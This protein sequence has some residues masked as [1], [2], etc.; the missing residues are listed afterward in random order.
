MANIA[1]KAYFENHYAADFALF[2]GDTMCGITMSEN[3]LPEK[4]SKFVGIAEFIVSQFELNLLNQ[5]IY[6]HFKSNHLARQNF[7]SPFANT[8]LCFAGHGMASHA[9]HSILRFVQDPSVRREAVPVLIAWDLLT[10][11]TRFF[12]NDYFGQFLSTSSD[13]MLSREKFVEVL[14]QD[15]DCVACVQNSNGWETRHVTKLLGE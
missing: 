8:L 9:P 4:R 11:Y 7:S 1:P 15:F 3:L 2:G 5:V 14:E 13:K 6:T 10:D 12:L